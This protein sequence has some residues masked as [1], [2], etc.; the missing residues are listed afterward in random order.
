MAG[1]AFNTD[2]FETTRTDK[3]TAVHDILEDLLKEY[4]QLGLKESAALIREA[5]V[6]VEGVKVLETP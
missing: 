5:A 6:C 4:E 1:I 3:L 2:K